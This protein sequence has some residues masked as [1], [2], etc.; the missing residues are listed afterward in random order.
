MIE[1][2][3]DRIEIS[4]PGKLL[5]TKKID[6]LIRTTPESRNEILAS[7]FRR[8]NICEERGSGLEKAVTAIE[9][10][11]LPPLRFE[12]LENS[13]R[14]TMYSPKTFAELT[15]K[16][17]VEACYQHSILKYYSGGGM[18]NTSL[19]E[20]FK[21]HE[22]QRPQVSLVIKDALEKGRI[23]PKDPNN[24]STKFAEYIP[25]WG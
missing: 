11:G 9:L 7:A 6:R 2:F 23:K 10:Y 8:Y 17:R 3:D 18:T 15:Q 5:P 14:V 20:R 1:I 12:E 21:M 25:I 22:K 13:F 19:R 16:E 4:N 24:V